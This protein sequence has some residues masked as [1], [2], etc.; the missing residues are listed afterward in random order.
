MKASQRRDEIARMVTTDG[1]VS[2]EDLGRLF[3]VTPSTIRRDLARL[4]DLL[5]ALR[6][7][8]GPGNCP[9]T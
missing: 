7:A 9:A 6:D 5:R 2:V 4:T 1:P 8:N 3:D